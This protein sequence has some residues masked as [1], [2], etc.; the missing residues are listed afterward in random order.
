MNSSFCC[1]HA[2]GFCFTHKLSWSVLVSPLRSRSFTFLILSPSHLGRTAW[3][4]LGRVAWG[5]RA[6]HWG[7]TTTQC[8]KKGT[9]LGSLLVAPRLH[10]EET[11]LR[12]EL[13]SSSSITHLLGSLKLIFVP[14]ERQIHLLLN[15][16]NHTQCFSERE[17]W[18]VWLQ[19]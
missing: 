6:A 16:T 1:A 12:Q 5:C 15:K 18:G 19:P 3:G 2:R 14:P 13:W 11:P 4:F 17:Y 7:E 10:S 8:R 9:R